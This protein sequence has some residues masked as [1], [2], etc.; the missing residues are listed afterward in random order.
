MHES[1][2][3]EGLDPEEVVLLAE[4]VGHL[5]RQK[6]GSIQAITTRTRMLGLNALIEAA[7]AG[8]SGKGFAVVAG[9]VKTISTKV[10][11]L[12]T[13]LEQE[14]VAQTT[15]LERL[16]RRIIEH[17]RGERLTDL[18]LNAIEI[19]DRNLYERTCDVRWWATDQAVVD[20]AAQPSFES[21]SY[22]AQRLGVILGS[23]TVYLDLWV[24]DAAGRVLANGQPQKYP[25]VCD[26]SVANEE[27]FV[28]A[29]ATH[30][31]EELAVAD[32][33]TNP[34]LD[35]A[36]VA[37]YSTAI[38]AG[39]R[40]DGE[41]TGVIAIHFDWGPQ[42]QAVVDGVRLTAEERPRTRVLLLD[43]AHR[44]I[45]SSDQRGVLGENFPLQANGRER[46]SYQ[47]AD[48]ATV[49]FAVTPGYETYRGLGWYGCI[50]SRGRSAES[51][52][53]RNGAS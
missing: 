49:S 20:C 18:A 29:M 37:T 3:Q 4:H 40:G 30:S 14:L 35:G 17:L 38:R 21:C 24:C 43:A 5:A 53:T 47:D 31:G 28:K 26:A 32:V 46:G 22:A 42:A 36:A 25:R 12:A 11:Q 6:I 52:P 23:Y 13:E 45:A 16:G 44:V 10:E 7:R 39:G 1:Q 9:E 41:I 15:R 51:A 8:E 34:L 2:S 19:I 50:V 27:W 48:G 33:A